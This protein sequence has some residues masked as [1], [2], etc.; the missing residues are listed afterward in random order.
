[1]YLCGDFVKNSVY[2]GTNHNLELAALHLGGQDTLKFLQSFDV[3]L[4]VV[5]QIE[6]EPGSAVSKN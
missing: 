3:C 1:M 5:F 2:L 4:A 6:P